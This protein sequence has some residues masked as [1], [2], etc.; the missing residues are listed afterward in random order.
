MI[1]DCHGHCTVD[2]SAWVSADD[3]VRGMDR[4]GVDKVCASSPI[5]AF[6]APPRAFRRQND[7]VLGAMREHPDRILGLCFV[8][9]GWAWAAQEEITRCVVDGG[10]VGIKLYNQYRINEP[11]QFPIIERAIELGIP[12]MMHSARHRAP[13]RLARQPRIS[14][15]E[16]FVEVSRRYPE[17][18]LVCYHISVADWEHQIK[19]LRDAPTVY[20]D[21]SGSGADAGL[22]ERAVRELGA[23]RLLFGCDLSIERGVGKIMDAE[24]SQSQRRMIL[25]DNMLGILSRRK[26]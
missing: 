22:I 8:N 11:V 20:A 6:D 10:M 4:Y 9:P 18:M 14:F 17:A 13:E 3:L 1:I 7:L 21:T 25:G 5:L 19:A 15:A 12:V 16:H 26:K 23:E 24:I 2:G